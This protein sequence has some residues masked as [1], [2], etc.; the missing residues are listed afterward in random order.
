[1][2]PYTFEEIYEVQKLTL[3]QGI[4]RAKQARVVQLEFNKV[5]ASN[6][7]TAG[8]GGEAGIDRACNEQHPGGRLISHSA[9][10]F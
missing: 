3:E 5:S 9:R 1:M 10:G 4:D 6:L 7:S 8:L 2:N